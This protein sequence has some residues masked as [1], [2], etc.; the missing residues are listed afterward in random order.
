VLLV[1]ERDALRESTPAQSLDRLTV[2]TPSG[3][4]A[5]RDVIAGNLGASA[6][7]I[8]ALVMGVGAAVIAV[9]MVSSTAG[10]RREFGRRRALG[11][12]RSTI[13]AG[14]LV[15]TGLCA[16]IGVAA[17]MV[18]GLAVLHAVAGSLPT[19]HFIAGVAGL[20]VL[21]ALAAAAPVAIAAALRDP[22]RILR[23]P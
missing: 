14:L 12:T 8:M 19:P 9:T 22:L 23:V 1:R 7:Q 11:A 15:Q 13:V 21:L 17:G 18:A 4:I 6:R 10:R 2:E 20:A 5:L 3:A 16:S